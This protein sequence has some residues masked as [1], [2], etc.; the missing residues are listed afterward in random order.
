MENRCL[1]EFRK[2]LEVEDYLEYEG[3]FTDR[4]IIDFKK[5]DDL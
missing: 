4:K 3:H 5:I 2:E 1:E